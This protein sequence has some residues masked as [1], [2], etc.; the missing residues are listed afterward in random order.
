MNESKLQIE[1]FASDLINDLYPSLN[2]ESCYLYGIDDTASYV[3]GA[4][5][6]LDTGTDIYKLLEKDSTKAYSA[7]YDAL[8]FFTFGWAA[9]YQ[10]GDEAPASQHPEKIRILLGMFSY[11]SDGSVVSCLKYCDDPTEELC[12][13]YGEQQGQLY[14]TLKS[15]YN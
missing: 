9:P 15:L 12:F 7:M 11:E 8:A 1:Q 3:P 4:A 14:D 10:P 6:H 13:Q 2:N 5:Y